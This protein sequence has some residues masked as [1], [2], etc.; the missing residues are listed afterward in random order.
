MKGEEVTEIFDSGVNSV[1]AFEKETDQPGA[2]AAAAAGDANHLISFF[3]H[4]LYRYPPLFEQTNLHLLV[5]CHVPSTKM[6]NVA[7]S[8]GFLDFSFS[9]LGGYFR[10]FIKISF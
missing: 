6:T 5:I 8:G 2:D 3:G 10:L 4:F 9:L 7:T 1:A